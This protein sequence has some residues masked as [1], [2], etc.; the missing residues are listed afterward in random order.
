[1]DEDDEA[2]D[3]NEGEQADATTASAAGSTTAA[4]TTA[5]PAANLSLGIPSLSASSTTLSAAGLDTPRGASATGASTP[6]SEADWGFSSHA[7]EAEPQIAAP[8]E[9]ATTT[10]PRISSDGTSGASTGSYDV[11]GER[12]GAPSERDETEVVTAKA[13]QDDEEEEDDSDW[14]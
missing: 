14:E 13:Q 9:V 2:Q 5:P 3:Q 4:R 6:A 12:S 7:G 1:M 11:V 8:V 10:S